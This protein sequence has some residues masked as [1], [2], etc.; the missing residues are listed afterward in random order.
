MDLRRESFPLGSM[1]DFNYENENSKLSSSY[2]IE[3]LSND[4]VYE[5]L[6]S[7]LKTCSYNTIFF[8]DL[9]NEALQVINYMEETYP[10]LK[11]K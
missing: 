7:I 9:S 10:E 2:L 6:L 5:H 11:K 3:Y 4:E 8:E 1:E